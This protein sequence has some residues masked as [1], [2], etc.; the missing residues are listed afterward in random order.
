[1]NPG[2]DRAAAHTARRSRS[3]PRR[4][5]NCTSPRVFREFPDWSRCGPACGALM[6]QGWKKSFNDAM[7]TLS[8]SNPVVAPATPGGAHR[9]FDTTRQIEETAPHG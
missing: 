9:R 1:M 2:T 7:L 5:V 6:H 4:S 8:V 3:Y